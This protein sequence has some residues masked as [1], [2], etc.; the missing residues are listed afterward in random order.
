[1]IGLAGDQDTYS[2]NLLDGHHYRIETAAIRDG[3][4]APLGT[5]TLNMLGSLM[6]Q[7][8]KVMAY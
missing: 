4:T 2:I 5:A 8:P 1:M 6:D 7:E 3:S